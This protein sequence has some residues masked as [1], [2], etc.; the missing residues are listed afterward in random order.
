MAIYPPAANI[1]VI[2]VQ[3]PAVV[4]MCS[5]WFSGSIPSRYIPDM[6]VATVEARKTKKEIRNRFVAVLSV[7]AIIL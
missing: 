3:I 2:L 1:P 4:M 7:I 6:M 5:Q